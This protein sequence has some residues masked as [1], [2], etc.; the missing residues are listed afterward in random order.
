MKK[1]VIFSLLIIVL[2]SSWVYYYTKDKK[3][4]ERPIEKSSQIIL[5]PRPSLIAVNL[6]FPYDTLTKEARKHTPKEFTFSGN[7]PNVKGKV[8]LVEYSVGTKYSY[9]VKIAPPTISK[10]SDN[11]KIRLSTTVSI[12]GSGGFRGTGAKILKLDK[13]NF[14][15]AAKA[16]VDLSFNLDENW[17]PLVTVEPSY[18]WID[19]PKVEIVSKAWIDVS[20]AVEGNLKDELDKMG[21]EAAKAISCEDIKKEVSQIWKTKSLTLDTISSGSQLFLNITP[22]K[23][24]FSEL[25]TNS[26]A[27]QVGLSIISNIEISSKRIAEASI[28]LPS[29]SAITPE[30][31][32]ISLAVPLNVP[33]AKL[34][35]MVHDSIVGQDFEIGTPS[36]KAIVKV[37]D[38]YLY[39]SGNKIAVGLKFEIDSPNRLF[40]VKGT[41]YL[42]GVPMIENNGTGFRLDN[43]EFTRVLDSELWSGLSVVLSETIKEKLS[44]TVRYDLSQKIEEFKNELAETLSKTDENINISLSESEISIGRIGVS[45]DNVFIEGF[46]KSKAELTLQQ[47]L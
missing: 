8:L 32:G 18:S 6:N 33:I 2:M 13:K 23:A 27:A 9:K 39:P 34:S 20:D 44:N 38:V 24:G 36:G 25:M 17:C 12:K 30:K 3:L 21:R 4:T 42:S 45:E 10:G 14:R 5:K 22:L 28:P 31:N 29:L 35:A 37:N 7:G 41:V 26:K 40:D 11:S 19:K 15:A 47:A 16:F 1:I 46:F 43:V